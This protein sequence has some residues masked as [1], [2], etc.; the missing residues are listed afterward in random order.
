MLWFVYNILF[1]VGYALML[2]RFLWRMWRRGGYGKGFTQRFGAYSTDVLAKLAARERIWIHAVSVGEIQ[3]AMKFADELRAAFP[4][5]GF[6]FTTNTSTAHALAEKRLPKDDVLLYFPVDF[7]CAVS[8]ALDAIKPKALLLTESEIWPNLIRLA[9]KR[10][11]PVAMVNG[12]ISASSFRGYKATRIFFSRAVNMIDLLLVQTDVEKSYLLALGARESR[13]SV[14]GS[15]KYDVVRR[16]AAGE[17]KARGVLRKLGM[18]ADDI[19]LLGGSTWPGEESALLRIFQ[20]L[21]AAG[22]RA[23]LVL[24][25]RH[26][27]RRAEVER[28]IAAVTPNYIKRSDMEKGVRPP[29]EVDVLLVDTTGELLSFYACASIVFVGK[30]LTS[31]GGQNV[32]EPAMLGKPVL[33]GPNMEN[34]AEVASDFLSAKAM[35]Q[36]H[37]EADLSSRFEALAADPG[38]REEYG[39]RAAEFVKSR[40]GAVQNSVRLIS[41]LLRDR[42]ASS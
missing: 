21:R 9:R 42:P 26:A 12:R 16:D 35:I 24:V 38:L 8:R 22:R 11:I 27:E 25:P 5:F 36:T 31:H 17:E 39:R 7:P 32:I 19:V 18:G 41:G 10:A 3:V 13:I 40:Q 23:K 2:P 37:D 1:A 34:F 20:A 4:E 30:S 15:A 6:V 28:E 29:A 33:T 14:L